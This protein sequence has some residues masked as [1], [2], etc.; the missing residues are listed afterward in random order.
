MATMLSAR[1]GGYENVAQRAAGIMNFNL[2]DANP[3]SIITQK[4]PIS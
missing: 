1:N 2:A 3:V 4:V